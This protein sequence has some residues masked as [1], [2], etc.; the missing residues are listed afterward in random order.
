M[1]TLACSTEPVESSPREVAPLLKEHRTALTTQ[2]TKKLGQD[3]TVHGRSEC[4][5]GLCLHTG[6]E[7]DKGYVCTQV[8]H[9]ATECPPE[10]HCEQLHPGSAQRVCVPPANGTATNQ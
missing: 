5:T 9:A 7:P 10:W 4:L 2:A 8:C 1:G 3:C 6:A